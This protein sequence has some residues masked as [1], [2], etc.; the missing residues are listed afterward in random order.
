[1]KI[2]KLFFAALLGSLAAPLLADVERI[3]ISSRETL[4]SADTGNAYELITGM[5]HF[6]LDPASAADSLVNDLQHAP[7][8][9]EGL[10]E[11]SAEF[12]L[13][14]PPEGSANGGLLYNVNNRG[15]NTGT[16]VLPPELS[17]DNPMATKGYTYLVSGWINEVE[18]G[19]QYVRLYAP[20]LGSESNPVTGLVRYE[21]VSSSRG[22]SSN[23]AA[24]S[25]HMAYAPTDA[26]LANAVLTRRPYQGDTREEIARGDYS[27]EVQAEDGSNQSRVTVHLDGGFEPGYI[28]EL[29]YEAKDPVLAGAGMAGIRDLV[30]LIRYGGDNESELEPLDLPPLQHFIAWGSSQSGRLLRNYLYDGFNADADGRIVFDGVIPFISGGGQGMFNQR[31]AMP[32]RTTQQHADYLF[33]NDRF[34][35]TYGDSTD[36]FTGRTDGILRKARASGTVPRVMH[37]QTT[38]EYWLRAGS[39]PHTNPEG[40]EDAVL[41]EEV[42]FYTIGGSQHG[43]GDGIPDGPSSSSQLV[44]NPNMW[45]PIAH[46][47]IDAMYHWVAHGV[48]PPPSRYPTISAGTLVPSHVDGRI[49]RD[50]WNRMPGI[51][52][53]AASYSPAYFDYGPRFLSEGIIDVQPAYS[54]KFYGALVPKVD[55]DNNDLAE[56]SILPPTTTVPLATFVSWNLRSESAGS[57][58][59]LA[60]LAGGYIPFAKNTFDAL[61]NRDPR[62]SI[63]GLYSSFADYHEKYNAA[64]DEL[65][66][67]RYL[68]P[69]YK[70]DYM[71]IAHANES[72]FE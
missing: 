37:I 3:E 49:N 57:E 70:G 68:L 71:R 41:P 13:F 28:Y 33:P 7:V 39:L 1:M 62:N 23:V 65:I 72:L 55:T 56:S 66:S 52:H 50:A 63:E 24:R 45:L 48:E 60:S 46:S 42:R 36:P 34:P 54:Q 6:T 61:A 5:I 19:D 51:S 22:R 20:V 12:K 26:G 32:T 10:V 29:I 40:T 27:I 35:F 11:Y 43:S 64:I 14:V 4:G 69:E 58:R 21:W 59:A 9:N 25:N 30:S 67:Q 47:L 53:P 2:R 18:P 38:N 44:R 16:S 15:R 17:L 31:F 8:N